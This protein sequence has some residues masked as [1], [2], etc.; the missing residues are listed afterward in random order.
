MTL[1]ERYAQ[2]A[3][4]VDTTQLVAYLKHRRH[5]SL[6]PKIVRHMERRSSPHEVVVVAREHDRAKMHHKFP[7]AAIEVDPKIVGGYIA[8]A[9]TEVTDA[10]YRRA[11]VQLYH[12]TTK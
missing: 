12:N 8:R 5:L 1:V 6:L 4:L 10:S 7:A 9:G 11:L 2:V 3:A